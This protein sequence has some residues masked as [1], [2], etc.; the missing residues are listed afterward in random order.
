[1]NKDMHKALHRMAIP[2]SFIAAG[3]LS[4]QNIK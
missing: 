1:M 4:A 3:E 2:L